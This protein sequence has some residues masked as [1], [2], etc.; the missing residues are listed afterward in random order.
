MQCLQCYH[1]NTLDAKFC[2]Q[3]ATPFVPQCSSCGCENAADAKCC[4]QCAT[5]LMAP[6]SAPGSVPSRQQEAESESRFHALLP[7]VMTLLQ[8]E[9]RVTY[10]RLK[11]IFSIDDVAVAALAGFS[12]RTMQLQFTIQE[13]TTLL[14]DG[15]QAVEIT[16]MIIKQR[17]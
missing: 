3:C 12:R 9:R 7:D 14:S 5:P 2:N 17:G 15:E 8:R 11:Y 13:G 6:T 1:E 16:P 4:N 10:R